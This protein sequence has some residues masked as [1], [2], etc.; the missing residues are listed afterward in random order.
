SADKSR[1]RTPTLAICPTGGIQSLALLPGGRK[2]QANGE[3]DP[4]PGGAR[5]GRSRSAGRRRCSPDE[6]AE[7]ERRAA[8]YHVHSKK[9]LIFKIGQERPYEQPLTLWGGT[10]GHKHIT[11][12]LLHLRH[13]LKIEWH[14]IN[15]PRPTIRSGNPPWR[16]AIKNQSECPLRAVLSPSHG[17]TP[18]PDEIPAT[19]LR[20]VSSQAHASVAINSSPSANRSTR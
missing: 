11:I 10:E 13:N 14:S 1:A 4:P 2:N 16:V 7:K 9:Y 18:P 17:S 15:D 5:R 20:K 6:A 8:R 12:N 19:P 3:A